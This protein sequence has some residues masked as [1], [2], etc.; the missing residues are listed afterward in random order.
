MAVITIGTTGATWGLTADT[1]VLIQT[2]SQKNSRDKNEVRDGQGDI[3]LVAYYN[4][5]GKISFAAVIAGST[6]VATSAPGVAQT[7]ANVISGTNGAPTGGVYVDDVEIAG[8]NTE[9]KKI[10]GSATKYTFA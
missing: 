3:Q 10:T 5:L 4:P 6:G 8:G 2:F 7:F 1:G 9:F